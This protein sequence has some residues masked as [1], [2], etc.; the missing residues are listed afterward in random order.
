MQ[1]PRQS[2]RSQNESAIGTAPV[3][4]SFDHARHSSP[5]ILEGGVQKT[6][7]HGLNGSI[8]SQSSWWENWR[9]KG[10]GRLAG[11]RRVGFM[12]AGGL[13]ALGVVLA[14]SNPP[15]SP[16]GT[17]G[18]P[19]ETTPSVS[20][21]DERNPGSSEPIEDTSAVGEANRDPR[22]VV[23]DLALS[24]NLEGAPSGI[25]DVTAEVVS[26]NGDIVL[27]DVVAS[28][29][30]TQLSFSVVLVRSANSWV[31]REVYSSAEPT[32]PLPAS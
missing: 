20:V 4:L 16:V 12:I 6:F 18:L 30:S 26:R 5:K 22:A 7:Y 3:V 13:C 2:V 23:V 28:V 29:N 15:D 32:Q 1:S 10:L 27:V 17:S 9:H 19:V 11:R 25:K 21:S 31:V 24:G 14:L 8:G